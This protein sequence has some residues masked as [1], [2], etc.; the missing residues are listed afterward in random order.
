MVGLGLETLRQQGQGTWSQTRL[1]TC[2]PRLR[3][4]FVLPSP[5]REHQETAV[6]AWLKGR[7]S[8]QCADQ[9]EAV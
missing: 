6:R 7:Q 1:Q 4:F 8:A 2:L 3:R 5:R 9:P